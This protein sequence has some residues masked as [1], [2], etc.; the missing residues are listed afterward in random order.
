[1]THEIQKIQSAIF[2]LE[3]LKQVTTNFFELVAY[4]TELQTCST[5][6][7]RSRLLSEINL[8]LSDFTDQMLQFQKHVKQLQLL[9]NDV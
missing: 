1:M 3:I 8:L 7:Y 2:D 4:C 9:Y 6:E 5:P